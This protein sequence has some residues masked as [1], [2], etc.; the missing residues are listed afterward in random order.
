VPFRICLA[1][2]RLDINRR[3]YRTIRDKGCLAEW[4][5]R[6]VG[7]WRLLGTEILEVSG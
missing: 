5:V 6:H 4:H 7:R 3:L 2:L 1:A